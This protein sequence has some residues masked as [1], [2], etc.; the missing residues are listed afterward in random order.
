MAAGNHR[1]PVRRGL[2]LRPTRMSPTTRGA[3]AVFLPGGGSVRFS[4]GVFAS[5][6]LFGASFWDTPASPNEHCTRVEEG[7]CSLTLCPPSVE[8]T[9]EVRP[10]AGVISYE[11]PSVP[12]VVSIAPNDTGR[13]FAGAA[14][15]TR[16]QAF[17][18]P[19]PAIFRA[20]G[21]DVPAFE[22]PLD[23]PLRILLDEPVTER[24][25]VTLP[26]SE[27]I[28]LR[29]SRGARGMI[30]NIQASGS[31]QDAEGRA[32]LLC[33]FDASVG[34]GT[35]PSSLLGF[36]AAETRLDLYGFNTT[37]IQSGEYAIRLGAGDQVLTPERE[38]PIIIILE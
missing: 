5:R 30:V 16:S 25:R 32:S 37:T 34:Q 20:T 10:H 29:W 35:L 2:G 24:G 14:E 31:R 12:G 26:R 18:E 36:M 22:A 33:D 19:V 15:D 17:L 8:S 28:V 1:R 6:A 21:G 13:Y 23:F 9:V 38:D 27:D 11:S 4:D 7:G 3:R